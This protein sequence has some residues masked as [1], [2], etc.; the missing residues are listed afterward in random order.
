MEAKVFLEDDLP[1]E[2]LTEEELTLLPAVSLVYEN[3]LLPDSYGGGDATREH[4][5][6][7]LAVDKFCAVDINAVLTDP[8]WKCLFER[9]GEEVASVE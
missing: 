6:K 5:A 1:K 2:Y 4:F 3:I 7:S 8:K 9:S